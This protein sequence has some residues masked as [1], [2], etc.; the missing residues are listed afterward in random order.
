M[1]KIG[2]VIMDID[3]ELYNA[4]N[5]RVDEYVMLKIAEKLGIPYAWVAGRYN[6]LL[7]D[8]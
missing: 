7:E 2:G 3:E 8:W 1:S 4:M 5:K 6:E